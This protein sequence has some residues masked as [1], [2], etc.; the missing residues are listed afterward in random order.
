VFAPS[1]ELVL[2]QASTLPYPDHFPIAVLKGIRAADV[3]LAARVKVL[4]GEVDQAA[5]LIWRVRDKSNYYGVLASAADRRLRLFRMV[6]GQG[7]LIASA[8]VDMANQL[9]RRAP[10]PSRGWYSL[11]VDVD[12]DRVV[13]RFGER[14][15]IEARDSTFPGPGAVG[16]VT[17]ADAVSAFDDVHVQT[18]AQRGQPIRPGAAEAPGTAAPPGAAAAP[19]PPVLHVEEIIV[20]DPGF[21]VP[22][23]RIRPG[24]P[25]F[26]KVRV[27]DAQGRPVAG[28][29]VDAAVLGPAGTTLA[30]GRAMTGTD[31]FG[32][33]S[34]RL[35][36]AG[37][38]G[39]PCTV[40]VRRLTD[41][42]WPDARYDRA[43]D[44]AAAATVAR[45]DG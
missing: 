40:V 37:T 9:E 17:H 28:A 10:L 20:T 12:G 26:F 18:G 31:G 33:F 1:P 3:T 32:L 15:A 39:G 13:V 29:I 5:G 36:A 27:G 30:S 38:P 14:R 16:L 44:S 22:V 2:L 35:P 42:D 34:R 7:S 19:G 8:P 23:Q 11:R 45:G 21:R 25:V 4:G 43:A 24:D 41:A 6:D